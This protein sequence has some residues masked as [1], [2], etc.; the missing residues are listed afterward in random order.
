MNFRLKFRQKVF[1][2][3]LVNSLIIVISMLVIGKYF[4]D[5]NFEKY[6]RKVERRKLNDLAEMLSVEYQKR[7]SWE[8]IIREWNHWLKVSDLETPT[9]QPDPLLQELVPTKKGTAFSPFSPPRPY[10]SSGPRICLLDLAFQP[11]TP[12]GNG[13]RAVHHT[14]AVLVDQ[15]T[16]GWLTIS[17]FESPPQPLDVEFLKHQAMV[18]Y[19][20][21]G[22]AL[23]LAI[24]VTF[25][26]SKHLAAPLKRLTAGT[27]ALTSMRFDTRID[28]PVQ[29][30]FGRL[31]SHFNAMA[32][33]LERH[34]Q[35]RRQWL[36]DI[37]HEL[38]TPLSILRGEIE[39]IQDGI[40]KA[41]TSSLESL[42]F[43]VL[44]LGQIVSDLHELSLMDTR[45]L[46]MEPIPVNPIEVLEETTRSFQTRFDANTI[47]LEIPAW[48]R[49]HLKIFADPVRLKQL[50]SNVLENTLRYAD[51][52]GLLKIHLEQ[53]PETIVITFEDSGPGV[54]EEALAYLFDRLFRVDKARS[55]AMGGS[56]LGLAICKGIVECFDG[57]IDAYPAPI[58]GLGIRIAFR[59]LKEGAPGSLSTPCFRGKNFR[60]KR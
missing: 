27:L 45:A 41:D 17:S 43:E 12:C 31:A 10:L 30:E 53:I 33:A 34:E 11:L 35:M 4:A 51:K 38:R 23:S 5:L 13:Q 60:E 54:P 57:R 49:F 32:Q 15:R 47:R 16:V 37:S 48:K 2:T 22:V 14:K 25:V 9:S 52:P 21:S 39:A 50:F 3:F 18:F 20:I 1:L 46:K 44:H 6:V 7:G 29:D 8:H 55:R 58:G 19:T 26:L 28:I 36:S 59:L 40:R 56:G 42:H 24:L